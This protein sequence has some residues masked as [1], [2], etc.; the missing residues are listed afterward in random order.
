MFTGKI[1]VLQYQ[2]SFR[3]IVYFRILIAIGPKML[4][5]GLNVMHCAVQSS[6]KT[7]RR[8]L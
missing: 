7:K 6:Q 1:N 5:L 8:Q 2:N 4:L 3:P